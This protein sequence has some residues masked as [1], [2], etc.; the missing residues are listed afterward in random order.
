MIERN[1]YKSSK[2]HLAERPATVM[3]IRQLIEQNRL[4]FDSLFRL[5]PATDAGLLASI[6]LRTRALSK[7]ISLYNS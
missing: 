4:P 7:R 3:Q 1:L 5:I 2:S 6:L